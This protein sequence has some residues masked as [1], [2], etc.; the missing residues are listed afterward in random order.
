M[1]VDLARHLAQTIEREL[2]NLRGLTDEQA[3]RPRA[4]GKWCAKEELGHLI[5]SAANNHIRFVRGALE[6]HVR[7]PG[8]AQDDWV[9]AHG[10]STMPWQKIVD[11]W[12]AYNSFLTGLVERIPEARLE[13]PCFIGTNDAVTLQFL[14]DDYVLHMQHHIDQ[15]LRRDVITQYPGATIQETG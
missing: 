14:I 3:S 13:T 9:R 5:D 2:P 6:S 10:Y 7:G 11:F 8:Y 1:A 4:V 12:F 15:L